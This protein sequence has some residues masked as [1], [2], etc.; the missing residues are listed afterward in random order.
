MADGG[1]GTHYQNTETGETDILWAIMDNFM[2]EIVLRNWLHHDA[3]VGA[4]YEISNR[5]YR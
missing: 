5:Y 2:S 3:G 4:E 1:N